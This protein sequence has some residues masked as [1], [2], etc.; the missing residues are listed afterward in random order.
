[1]VALGRMGEAS[2]PFLKEVL[3]GGS[4]LERKLIMATLPHATTKK[5]NQ[6]FK[7]GLRDPHPEIRLNAIATFRY[8]SPALKP[9]QKKFK[10]LIK[11]LLKK[12]TQP[13]VIVGGSLIP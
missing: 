10:K 5:A 11:R 6:L 12:E 7:L 2:L 3:T 4:L 9:Y 13:D 1:M 8:L